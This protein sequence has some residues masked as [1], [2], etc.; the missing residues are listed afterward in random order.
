MVLCREIGRAEVLDVGAGV[1]VDGAGGYI[2][3]D[4]DRVN[5]GD[6]YP[7]MRVCLRKVA[8]V[9]WDLKGGGLLMKRMFD[10]GDGGE[11]AKHE[12]WLC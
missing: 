7:G 6:Q 12:V 2:S 11:E 10:L 3:A 5:G 1:G 4:E 8:T 9:R